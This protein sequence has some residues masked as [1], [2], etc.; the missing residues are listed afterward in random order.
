M[1]W[2]KENFLFSVDEVNPD[3]SSISTKPVW[4]N[5]ESLQTAES[6]ASSV[7]QTPLSVGSV[8]T[9]DSLTAISQSSVF[10]PARNDLQRFVS[11]LRH[12][13]DHLRI[14]KAQHGVGMPCNSTGNTMG[15]CSVANKTTDSVAVASGESTTETRRKTAPDLPLSSL[16]KTRLQEFYSPARFSLD[17]IHGY[18]L[19]EIDPSNPFIPDLTGSSVLEGTPLRTPLLLRR[20]THPCHF[21]RA[22]FQTPVSGCA[23][24]AIRP[25]RDRTEPRRVPPLAFD[26]SLS[27]TNTPL[28][29]I[30]ESVLSVT[31][32]CPR[33]SCTVRFKSPH[34]FF[35]C[36]LGPRAPP[37]S[38]I[39]FSPQASDRVCPA[40]SEPCASSPRR[41]SFRLM[42][43]PDYLA[44]ELLISSPLVE[45]RE[46]AAVDWWALG[47]IL[48]EML[49]GST[50]FGDDTPEAIFQNIL[51]GDI[52]WPC[53]MTTNRLKSTAD[54]QSEAGTEELSP[55]AV[56]LIKGLL[57]RSPVE[58][59]QVASHLRHCA[60][61]SSF[62]DWDHLDQ[63]EMPF[64]PCPD[65]STDTSYFEVRN[66][67]ND[68]HITFSGADLRVN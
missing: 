20:Q 45:P 6:S 54:Q 21:P 53:P 25:R 31:A 16:E 49:T 30:T 8:L 12:E 40:D 57:S 61:L 18:N 65:D 10:V 67:M 68:Y 1:E 28:S 7:I 23:S 24:H 55:D 5:P 27:A 51:H 32:D 66:K 52:P 43:T 60:F 47:I 2:P 26:S 13:L 35:G 42:G 14:D 44:P 3:I 19:A 34:S 39:V 48:F 59:M 62:K 41:Q 38:P 63:L 64:V 58:R 33:R 9:T 56:G 46:T 11:P 15:R 17:N 36:D 29:I 22:Q 4:I 37:S 50:P